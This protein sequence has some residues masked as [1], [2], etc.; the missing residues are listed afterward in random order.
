MGLHTW[1]DEIGLVVDESQHVE[2]GDCVQVARLFLQDF[3]W[4]SPRPS[5]K[6]LEVS[7]ALIGVGATMSNSGSPQELSCR[8]EFG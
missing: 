5:H 3:R 2:F 6:S 7:I 1:I 4:R 8:R